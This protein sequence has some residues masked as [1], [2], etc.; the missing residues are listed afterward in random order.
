MRSSETK[1]HLESVYEFMGQVYRG[2]WQYRFHE[3]PYM[4]EAIGRGEKESLLAHELGCIGHWFLLRRVCPN[5]NSLIDSAKLYEIFFV[6]DLGEITLGDVS[7]VAQLAGKGETKSADEL[8][9]IEDMIQSLPERIQKE[10]REYFTSFENKS[11]STDLE[12]L[13]ARFIDQLEG[14]HFVLTFGKDLPAY[15]EV[16]NKILN[17]KFIARAYQLLKELDTLGKSEAYNEILAVSLHHFQ[18]FRNAGVNV[19]ISEEFTILM[20]S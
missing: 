12:M 15:S 7:N 19:T 4:E 11:G 3:T 6:H 16:I 8:L 17:R 14:N 1:G 18:S 13:V 2:G 10:I 20:P 9:E 5:L